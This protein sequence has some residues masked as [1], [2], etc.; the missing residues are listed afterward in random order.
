[1]AI[2]LLEKAPILEA[3]IESLVMRSCHTLHAKVLSRL[4]RLHCLGTL[5]LVGVPHLDLAI[6]GLDA[7][8][9]HNTVQQNTVEEDLMLGPPLVGY[10]P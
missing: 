4:A 6:F 2:G 3:P 8:T 10:V 7:L 1:M 5:D 9:P